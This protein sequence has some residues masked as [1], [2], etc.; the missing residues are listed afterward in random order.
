MS[1][2]T[3]VR[4]SPVSASP[5]E[6]FKSIATVFTKLELELEAIGQLGTDA[7]G[8][9]GFLG[10]QQVCQSVEQA[11]AY[12]VKWRDFA[13]SCIA[14]PITDRVYLYFWTEDGKNRFSM[15]VPATAPTSESEVYEAGQWLKQLLLAM[16]SAIGA[17]VCVYGPPY[18]HGLFTAVSASEIVASARRGHLFEIS[19]PSVHIVSVDLI[20]A[21]EFRSLF[22][23][24][25]QRKP[26][27]TYALALPGYNVLSVL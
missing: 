27:I 20:D 25:G 23:L 24:Y 15:E 2:P 5:A 3:A 11:L 1:T 14:Y 17:D 13:V 12:T 26:R 9:F 21:D 18:G 8:E 7:E 6:A 22:D 10:E 4:F 19:Y 16:T